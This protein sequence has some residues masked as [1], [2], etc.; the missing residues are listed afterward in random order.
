MGNRRVSICREIT[1]KYEETIVT[2]LK[3]AIDRYESE[4]PKGEFVLVIEGKSEDELDEEERQKWENVSLE[5][6]M[7]MYI[8]E[9]LDK[10]AAMKKVAKDKGVSKRDIYNQ[11]LQEEK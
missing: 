11:L 4:E 9:G 6:H 5:K 8:D 10:K 2:T 1:K 7:R 3:E